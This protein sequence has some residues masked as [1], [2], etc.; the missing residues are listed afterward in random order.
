MKKVTEQIGKTVEEAI[1]KGLEELKVARDDVIVEVLEEPEQGGLLG[2]LSSKH[3][4][5]RII[6]DKK[7]DKEEAESTITK[8]KQIL[9][10]I[11]NITGEKIEYKFEIGDNQLNVTIDSEDAA[12]LIGYKG[13]TIESFQSLLNSILQKQDESYSKIFLEINGYKKKK[14]EKLKF[15]ARKMADNV[16]KY[17]KPIK[18][19]PMSPYERMIVHKE[20]ALRKDIVTESYGEEPRRYVMIKKKF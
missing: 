5:V 12:H 8:V 10:D 15:L 3:A 16:I 7:I 17:R 20:L 13:K 14:E 9:D 2:V 19:E 11:F 6:V 1:R 18:L 4:K